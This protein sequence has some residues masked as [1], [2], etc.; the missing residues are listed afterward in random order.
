METII[1]LLFILLPVIFKFIEK[2]L[3]SSTAGSGQKRPDAARPDVAHTEV[4]GSDTADADQADEY[5]ERM[6]KIHELFLEKQQAVFES[7]GTRAVPEA[8]AKAPVQS[9]SSVQK[10]ARASSPMLM[11]ESTKKKSERID[12]KKLVI[13]SEIMKPKHQ[14]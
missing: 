7:E 8:P 3:Q 11:E 1:G 14:D 5:A 6:K 10:R 13:Y 2:R 9:N 4:L 12:P